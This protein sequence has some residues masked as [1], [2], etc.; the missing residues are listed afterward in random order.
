MEQTIIK[1]AENLIEVRKLKEKLNNKEYWIQKA[2]QETDF[3]PAEGDWISV[4]VTLFKIEISVYHK[5]YG[6]SKYWIN[7]CWCNN[8]FDFNYPMHEEMLAEIKD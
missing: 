2:A 3:V 6:S 8:P 7:G 1:I 5:H 4:E